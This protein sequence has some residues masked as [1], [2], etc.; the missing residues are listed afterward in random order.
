MK[1]GVCVAIIRDERV[2]LTK[3]SDFEV[4]CLPGGH[5][6]EGES[7]AQT[8]VRET[9]EETGLEVKLTFMIGL[10]SIPEAKAWVNLMV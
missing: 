6:D 1:V 10:Y 4:W 5:V 9:A 3:R 7:I 8:A 2:L